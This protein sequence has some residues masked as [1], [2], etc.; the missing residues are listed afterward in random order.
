MGHYFEAVVETLNSVLE[1]EGISQVRFVV[2]PA[3][4]KETVLRGWQE[5]DENMCL[6]AKITL[7]N[8]LDAVDDGVR[9]FLMWDSC[10]DCRYKVYHLLQEKILN[11]KFSDEIQMYRFRARQAFQDLMAIDPA[12]TGKVAA[13]ILHRLLWKVWDMDKELLNS[14]AELDPEKPRIG[15]VG[16][17]YTI[18]EPSANLKLLEKI[19]QQGAAIHNSLPLSEFVFKRLWHNKFFRKLGFKRPDIDYQVKAQAEREAE[20]Y[21]PEYTVGGHGKESVINTIYYARTGFDSVLHVQPFPCMPE[22]TVSEFLDEISED[23][24]IPVNHLTFDQQ[25][26]E[27]NL[28]TR[29]EAMINMLKLGKN[30][31]QESGPE[32]GKTKTK[33]KSDRRVYLGIDVGSVSTKGVVMD[34]EQNIRDQFYL[35]TS[36]DPV[37][38]LQQGLKEFKKNDWNING[39]VTTGSGRKLARAVVDANLAIDEITAQ[40]LGCLEFFPEV[41]SVIEIGGQDSK[42]IKLKNGAPIWF[43]LNSICSA[44]TGSFCKEAAREFGYSIEQFG[45][46]AKR[47]DQQVK[48]TG[49]CGVFMESDLVTK[50]QQGYSKEALV[51]GVCMA[52]PQNFLNNVA[53][54][55]EL[56]T[57]IVFTG[58]VA[59]NEGVVEGFERHLGKQ[60]NVHRYNKISGAYGAC[61]YAQKFDSRLG[62]SG[63]GFEVADVDFQRKGFT[64]NDCANQCE[65]SLLLKERKVVTCFGSKCG[66][67]EGLSGKEVQPEADPDSLSSMI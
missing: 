56:E 36:R 31:K 55:R 26:G 17:I 50:Q 51:R 3:T 60:V 62:E 52:M 10:G 12:I 39:V 53:R 54:N 59:S 40:T 22:S 21:F 66:K 28:N 4:T 14:Q 49:R 27:A 46:I 64:C 2:A 7:G 57:P 5:M 24:N 8:M 29:V 19:E 25:F 35:E 1:E 43:N 65:V 41:R 20:E 61:L 11:R 37:K 23:Y 44:G 15:I 30:L 16:E 45:E 38:A 63:F 32:L 58:G 9:D 33:N 6:P 48:V 67:W 18:L 34:P 47:T 42:F 13:K